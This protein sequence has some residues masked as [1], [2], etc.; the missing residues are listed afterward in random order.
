M[1]LQKGP[2]S[3]PHLSLGLSS[4]ARGPATR[5]PYCDLPCSGSFRCPLRSAKVRRGPP[6]PGTLLHPRLD[7]EAAHRLAPRFWLETPPLPSGASQNHC[8]SPFENAPWS[9][10]SLG[11]SE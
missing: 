11:S 5:G 3:S 9:T 1:N 8:P 10:P 2:S 4:R 6:S 7:K